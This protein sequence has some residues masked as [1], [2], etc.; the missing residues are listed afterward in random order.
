MNHPS[1]TATKYST[2]MDTM[3]RY[4]YVVFFALCACA[5][6]KFQF[7]R[8]KGQALDPSLNSMLLLIL[9][10]FVQ[11]FII[12]RLLILELLGKKTDGRTDRQTDKTV[13]LRIPVEYLIM[14]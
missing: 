10:I 6:C 13:P 7:D 2:G 9:S 4:T 5:L 3:Y 8:V 1:G 12:P 11:S 14:I